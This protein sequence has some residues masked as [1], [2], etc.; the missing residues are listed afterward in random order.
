M[1]VLLKTI[2]MPKYTQQSSQASYFI[3]IDPPHILLMISSCPCG[4][5]LSFRVL[6]LTVQYYVCLVIINYNF[7][8]ESLYL[9]LV[10]VMHQLCGNCGRD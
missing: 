7:Y 2:V 6:S 3:E 8:I 10:A 9:K 4:S 1:L 5:V